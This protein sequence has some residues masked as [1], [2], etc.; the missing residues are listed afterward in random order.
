MM[1]SKTF[2]MLDVQSKSRD[3]P[4]SSMCDSIQELKI[5]IPTTRV[6]SRTLSVVLMIGS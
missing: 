5:K 4:S 2:K 1:Y 3:I 6:T